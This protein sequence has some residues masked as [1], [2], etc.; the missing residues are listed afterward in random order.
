MDT[1]QQLLRDGDSFIVPKGASLPPYC[2]KCGSSDVAMASKD[3]IWLNPWLYL[4]LALGPAGF[5]IVYVIGRQKVKLLVPLCGSHEQLLRRLR[6]AATVF[7]VGGLPVGILCIAIGAKDALVMTG[8]LIVLLSLFGA[9]ITIHKQ[10]P[11]KATRIA[12]GRATFTGACDAFLSSL[13]K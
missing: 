3:F 13:T 4:G 6:F 1:P 9:L 5:L 10:S 7:L 8:M 12:D 2:V 11:L